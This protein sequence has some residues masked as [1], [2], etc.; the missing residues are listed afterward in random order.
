M[1]FNLDAEYTNSFK[2]KLSPELKIAMININKLKVQL[3]R[4]MK[5]CIKDVR[6]DFKKFDK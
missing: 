5:K 6:K 1:A 2:D 4:Q 3:R